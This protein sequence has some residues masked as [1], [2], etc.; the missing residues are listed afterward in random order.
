MSTTKPDTLSRV[1]AANPAPVRSELGRSDTAQETLQR[2][3]RDRLAGTQP[4]R[5]FRRVRVSGV[6]V[7]VA[8]MLVG[9]GAAI[10]ATNPFGWWSA[11]PETARFAVDPAVRVPTP[12][13]VQIACPSPSGT[14]FICSPTG[15]GQ[16]YQKAETVQLPNPTGIFTRARFS[17][18]IA[19]SEAL[20]R[21]SSSQAARLRHDLA[22]VPDSFFTEL[23]LANTYQTIAGGNGRV[24][25]PGIPQWLVCQDAGSALRCQD[26]NGDEHAPL[27]GGHLP[28]RAGSR[29]ARRPAG[30][31]RLAA[32]AGH[33]V[34]A[35][36]I[37]VP[38]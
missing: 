35:D 20:H 21:L 36:R 34:H 16:R 24:P 5:R 32:T 11:N 23:R 33:Q 37:P 27:G 1:R 8:A 38:I 12:L 3:L 28:R 10:A 25:P 4:R 2:I 26:L 7:A 19:H 31:G 30:Q 6:G 29:L 22:A 13:A 15:P 9:G 14:G 18:A 17:H